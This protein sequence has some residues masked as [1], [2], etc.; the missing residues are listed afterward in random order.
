MPEE[1][2]DI[3]Q[4]PSLSKW[5]PEIQ[6]RRPY[7]LQAAPG[8]QDTQPRTNRRLQEN[9]WYE[10]ALFGLLCLYFSALWIGAVMQMLKSDFIRRARKK[11]Q[12]VRH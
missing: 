7:V 12:I 11:L 1:S 3:Q 4:T 9:E 5:T 10:G 6:G 2:A 8:N